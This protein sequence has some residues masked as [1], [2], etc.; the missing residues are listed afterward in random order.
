MKRT[1]VV[2]MIIVLMAFAAGCGDEKSGTSDNNAAAQSE[3]GAA[4]EEEAATDA[5]EED[6]DV[7]VDLTTLNS[8]MVYG[9]VYEMLTSPDDYLGKE[10]KMG[11]QF[12]VYT[13]EA[14]GKN[15]FACIIS[16]ATA[17]CSQG[18]E[19]EL[20]GEHVYPDDY[21]EQGAEITVIGTFDTYEEGGTKYCTLREAK[22]I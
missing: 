5:A 7:D 16:D 14:T 11:G 4:V 17:C 15:Y 21:P 9:Q 2:F 1:I 19:F 20:E 22:M 6:A 13:D 3:S 12:A 18:M 8:T 10:I